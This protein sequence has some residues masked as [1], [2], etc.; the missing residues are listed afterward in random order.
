MEIIWLGHSCFR[1]KG[2]ETTLVADPFH[3]SLGYSL[4][5]LAAS[6]VTVSHPH[7]GH[8]NALEVRGNPRIVHRP[9]EY[10]L[11]RVFITG[12]ATFHD[13][14]QGKTRGKNTA[15]LIEMD[16][17]TLCHLGDLG[18][19][20]SPRQVEQLGEVQVLLLPVGGVSTI[21]MKTAADIVRLLNPKIVIPMHYRTPV[22]PWLQPVE[23]FLKE[24]G[25]KQAVPQPKL[26][27]TKPSMPQDTTVILLDYR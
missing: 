14:E 12:I 24:I 19:K 23:D 17:I 6:I 7:P 1:I 4:D 3:A 22:V 26:S 18:H 20:L 5:K 2:K 16:E 8:S 15:Y 13:Q 21:D 9:G 11:S 27:V 25:L 10:E